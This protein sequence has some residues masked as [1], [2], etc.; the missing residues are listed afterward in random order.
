MRLGFV[1]AGACTSEIAFYGIKQPTM[2][3]AK[4]L[5]STRRCDCFCSGNSMRNVLRSLAGM[6]NAVANM[7]ALGWDETGPI[8]KSNRAA[9]DLALRGDGPGGFPLPTLCDSFFNQAM[10]IS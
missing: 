3:D 8:D 7:A 9:S 6:I 5:Q 4:D 1:A 10:P 2:F